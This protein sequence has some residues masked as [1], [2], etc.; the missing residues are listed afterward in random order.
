MKPAGETSAG[1]ITRHENKINAHFQPMM[2]A[3]K[4][5]NYITDLPVSGYGTFLSQTDNMFAGLFVASCDMRLDKLGVYIE[6]PSEGTSVRLGVYDSCDDFVPGDLVLDAGVV[7]A[8]VK[9]FA[10]IAV[11]LDLRRGYY[12]LVCLIENNCGL[13]YLK[14]AQS[15]LGMYTTFNAVFSGYV[16]E[17]DWG[18]LPL[19]FPGGAYAANVTKMVIGAG[20]QR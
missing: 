3:L 12:Y 8:S 7:D 10:Q 17:Q 6:T 13:R 4:S 19:K 1:A 2:G 18:E 15:P 11:N 5:G 20:E 16:C 14:L 9:G